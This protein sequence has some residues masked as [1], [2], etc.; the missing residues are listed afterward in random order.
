MISTTLLLAEGST[1]ASTHTSAT[2]KT[3]LPAISHGLSRACSRQWKTL[4]A[5]RKRTSSDNRRSGATQ[6]VPDRNMLNGIRPARAAHRC[7]ACCVTMG[8]N[9][10]HV[11]DGVD[12]DYPVAS[13]VPDGRPMIAVKHRTC[14]LKMLPGASL[15]G[16]PKVDGPRITIAPSICPSLSSF[17]S[18]PACAPR[19]SQPAWQAA[20]AYSPGCRE[21][22]VRS[23]SCCVVHASRQFRS[24]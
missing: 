17:S 23:S 9:R 10:G 24:A 4:H 3:T 1:R 6:A 22:C 12:T 7:M 14:L 13:S 11:C 5:R 20:F 19:N 16:S 15:G 2:C 8:L 21:T 18:P